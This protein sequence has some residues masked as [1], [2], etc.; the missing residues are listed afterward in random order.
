MLSA[1]GTSWLTIVAAWALA[2]TVS[3]R[4]EKAAGS[5]PAG[6]AFLIQGEYEGSLGAQE[7]LA[8]QVVAEG[9]GAFTVVFLPGGLPGAG[10]DGTSRIEAKAATTEGKTVMTGAWTGTLADGTLSGTNPDG[11]AFSLRRVIRKSPTLGARPPEGA[12]VLFD[13]S[14]ADGWE[15]TRRS[16]GFKGLLVDDDGGK[17]LYQ[18]AASKKAFRDCTLHVEFRMPFL[19]TLRKLT[20]S[21]VYVQGR[22]E[23]QILDTFAH[24]SGHGVCGALY[25]V[26]AP[27]VNMCFPP[28]SWQT[29]DIEFR[30]ARYGADGK[31]TANARMAVRHNG[32][33]VYDEVEIKDVTRQAMLKEED[34]PGPV[35]FQGTWGEHVHFRNIWLVEKP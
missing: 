16:G 35:Y 20:N 4:Q 9:E 34:G 11:R 7:K 24:E 8:A 14:T 31:K 2:G 10:W 26:R 30:A 19:P 6:P 5:D 28:L 25:E 27:A 21:G 1:R 29:F 18:G 12:Q 17:V 22:Y 23:V 33:K 32:V 15:P 13:G 3:G